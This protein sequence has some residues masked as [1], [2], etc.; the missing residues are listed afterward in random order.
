MRHLGVVLESLGKLAPED[1]TGGVELANSD[2]S[3]RVTRLSRD[4]LNA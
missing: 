3:E 4:L 2:P 1:A